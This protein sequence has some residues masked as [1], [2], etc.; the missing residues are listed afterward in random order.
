M[1]TSS[2][3]P[4]YWVQSFAGTDIGATATS[5]LLNGG[6]GYILPGRC[7]SVVAIRPKCSSITSTVDQ[8]LLC[9]L[10]LTSPDLQ[11]GPYEEFAP[12]V[13]SNLGTNVSAV[14][15]EARWYPCNF[16]AG[17]GETLNIYGVLEIAHTSHAWMGVDILLADQP[18]APMPGE[19]WP[20]NQI[21]DLTQPV[22]A[23][24]GGIVEGSGPTTQTTAATLYQD[25]GTKMSGSGFNS[26]KA[27]YGVNVDTTPT[28]SE[29]VQGLFGLY[30][31]DLAQNPL[32]F[33]S[34]TP[35]AGLLGTTTASQAAHITKIE[36]LNVKT[37]VSTTLVGQ[38][39]P[40]VTLGTG[41]KFEVGFLY[42]GWS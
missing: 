10:N 38:Y 14:N 20:W 24:I 16:K 21:L 22:W 6:K 42:Q 4:G 40:D 30:S 41:G 27:V 18:N 15:D 39:T 34:E 28:A 11:L 23:K 5:S 33:Y 26:I 8:S 35:G 12:P 32:L 31:T 1:P 3:I 37:K 13:G 9:S 29:P 17:G 7:K 36:G 25:G 19:L 2:S